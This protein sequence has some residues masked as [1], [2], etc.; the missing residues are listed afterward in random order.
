MRSAPL[1]GG[2]Y[3][4]ATADGCDVATSPRVTGQSLGP[5]SIEQLAQAARQRHARADDVEIWTARMAKLEPGGASAAAGSAVRAP[6]TA[7]AAAATRREV[8]GAVVAAVGCGISAIVAAPAPSSR[9]RKSRTR[10]PA[11]R[12]RATRLS[13]LIA[14]RLPDLSGRRPRSRFPIGWRDRDQRFSHDRIEWSLIRVSVR[15]LRLLCARF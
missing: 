14:L 5:Y 3:A 15:W 9:A 1:G 4:T 2:V 7:A 8:V 10:A 6:T 12:P 11:R 13:F